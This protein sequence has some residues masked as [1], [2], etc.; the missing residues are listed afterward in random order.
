LEG[1]T[2]RNLESFLIG[3]RGA[4]RI[5]QSDNPGTTGTTAGPWRTTPAV[6]ASAGAG[7]PTMLVA[8]TLAAR[9]AGTAIPAGAAPGGALACRGAKKT[10]GRGGTAER[11]QRIAAGRAAGGRS[12]LIVPSKQGN[13]PRRILWREARRRPAGSTEG[14]MP[15]TS[16][17]TRM[18]TGLGWIAT[19]TLRVWRIRRL[20]NGML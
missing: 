6:G 15:N 13:S 4:G 5:R 17:F 8:A 11:R 10:G 7:G 14:N 16:R 12:P 19:G 3:L 9:A 1:D 18:S 20:K 2:A